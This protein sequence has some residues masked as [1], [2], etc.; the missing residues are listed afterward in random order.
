MT[1]PQ[2]LQLKLPHLDV[3]AL[4]WGPA[5]GRL[6]LCLHGFPDSAWGW[7]KMAPLLAERGMR[8]VAPFSR[9]Y[10]PTGPAADGDYHIGALMYDALAVHTE[11]GAPADAVLIGHDW[12]AFTSSAIAAYPDS[13]FAEHISMAVPPVGAINK[14]RGPVG[15]QLRM[16]PQQL[17]NSWY[18][19][20][21]Q[22]P[23][24]PERLLPR[25]IPRLWRDWGPP[26]YPTDAELNE[27]LAALPS[28]AHRRAAV[29]YY[30]AL[31]RPSRPAPRY[32]ELDR[33]RF[34]LP[35]APVLHL[36]GA[37]DGAMMA[38]YAEQVATVLP[39]GS[40]VLTI[41]SAGHFLQIE[42]P[43]VVAD[44]VLDY[45]DSR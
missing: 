12:G 27:A 43:R 19:V 33:W 17:R 3:A 25:V 7:R 21:F 13:P 16:M 32:R 28:P 4:S 22:L 20:F 26:G 38:E 6:V 42:Q 23:G 5:D 1:E 11:L 31:A 36:Q 9:G 37:Q 41:P 30:R 29:S 35:R 34:E 24:L 8:V 2:T 10:A 45:L 18:I 39:S 44:A 40:R 15:R 14:T